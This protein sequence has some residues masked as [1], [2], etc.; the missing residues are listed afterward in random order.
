MLI[1]KNPLLIHKNKPNDTKFLFVDKVNITSHSSKSPPKS[2]HDSLLDIQH[3]QTSCF[4]KETFYIC[5]IGMQSELN[6]LIDSFT[7]FDQ[8]KTH[9]YLLNIVQLPIV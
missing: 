1:S 2:Y 6:I 8:V 9:L 5:S 7:Q 3:P 4:E